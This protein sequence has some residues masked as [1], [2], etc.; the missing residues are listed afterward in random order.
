MSRNLFIAAFAVGRP[1][2]IYRPEIKP[3]A[4]NPMAEP[5]DNLFKVLYAAENLL[6]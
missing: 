3:T 5:S 6:R 1:A 2:Q 4:G